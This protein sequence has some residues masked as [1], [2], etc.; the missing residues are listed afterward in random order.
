MSS[1]DYN[2]SCQKGRNDNGRFKLSE[3][4]KGI[5]LDMYRPGGT[6]CV[7]V[8]DDAQSLHPERTHIKL[9][10]EASLRKGSLADSIKQN[11][12]WLAE[13]DFLAMQ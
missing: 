1:G 8:C 4:K 7:I 5:C 11:L 6:W 3:K 2:G 10:D 12:Y 9:L 13:L